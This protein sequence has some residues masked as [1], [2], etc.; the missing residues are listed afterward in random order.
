MA[1]IVRM[2]MPD[3]T[4]LEGAISGRALYDGRIEP[5]EALHV[6]RRLEEQ[7]MTLGNRVVPCLDVKDLPRRAQPPS[8]DDAQ[9]SMGAAL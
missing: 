1:D 6:L 5:K 8:G 7:Q 4:R 9:A 2:T 3:A